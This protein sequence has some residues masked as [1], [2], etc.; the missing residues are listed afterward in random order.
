MGEV[1][2]FCVIEH[3]STPSRR[4]EPWS[5]W[6]VFSLCKQQ[7]HWLIATCLDLP[8]ASRPIDVVVVSSILLGR[9][10]LGTSPR[11]STKLIKN[12]SRNHVSGN[13]EKIK[14]LRVELGRR[15]ETNPEITWAQ[16]LYTKRSGEHT[17][18]QLCF[19]SIA[20]MCKQ[21]VCCTVSSAT[22]CCWFPNVTTL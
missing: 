20:G 8:R 16:R 5:K 10:S 12:W 3:I 18:T 19:L 6:F 9:S 2:T 22:N 13:A 7:S 15:K 1:T 17:V 4:N 21:D 14:H 11:Y